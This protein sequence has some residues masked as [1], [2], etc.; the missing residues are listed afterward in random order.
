MPGNAIIPPVPASDVEE[1][2]FEDA[3]PRSVATTGDEW[4]GAF[5]ATESG[6]YLSPTTPS[7]ALEPMPPQINGRELGAAI[8]AQYMLRKQL[9]RA[10]DPLR[11]TLGPSIDT[12]SKFG[13]SEPVFDPNSEELRSAVQQAVRKI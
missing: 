9:E 5:G 7:P 11:K 8:M 4:V 10:S 6:E 1:D 2:P 3:N 12:L 13:Y